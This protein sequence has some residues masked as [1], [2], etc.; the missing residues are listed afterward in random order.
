MGQHRAS[1]GR[2]VTLDSA[3]IVVKT[4]VSSVESPA[5]SIFN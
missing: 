2:R 1:Q 4:F 3:T 5:A